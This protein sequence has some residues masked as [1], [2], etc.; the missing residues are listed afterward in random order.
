[1]WAP[2]GHAEHPPRRARGRSQKGPQQSIAARLPSLRLPPGGA[3]ES[4]ER[5]SWPVD[6]SPTRARAQQ[7]RRVAARA[8]SL[9]FLKLCSVL[10]SSSERSLDRETIF[11]RSA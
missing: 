11:A 6:L 8:A 2:A 10:G 3:G 7:P 4:R 1:M 5:R 9:S